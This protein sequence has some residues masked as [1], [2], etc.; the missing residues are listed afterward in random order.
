MLRKVE[1][2][3][4][5]TGAWAASSAGIST[6]ILRN[7]PITEIRVTVE[8]TPSATLAGANA[9]DGIFRVIQ[10]LSIVGGSQ[11]Y[12]TLPSK[13]E[14]VG[15]LLLHEMNMYDGAS[16]GHSLASITAPDHTYVPINFIFHAGV[17]PRDKY[18]KP[19]PFD[20]SGFIPATQENRLR[21]IWVTGANTVMDDTVTISS[22]TMR[23]TL[24]TLLGSEAEIEQ[25]MVEQ[26]VKL[27]AG[28]RAMVP[29][30]SAEM[31]SHTA[32]GS[33]YSIERNVPT[34]GFLR[35]IVIVQQDNTTTGGR[36][37]R[38]A[39]QV[40]GVAVKLGKDGTI[41]MRANMDQGLSNLPPA[42]ALMD[43]DADPLGALAVP[44]GVFVLDLARHVGSRAIGG[45]EY[46]LN[47]MGR[48]IGV[49]DIKLGFTITTYT[50]G[51]QSAILYE[52]L[53]PVL[54]G[55]RFA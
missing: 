37:L 15:G 1:E 29:Q 47:M 30:W 18:G 20:A 53:V 26:E 41:L 8:T 38:A 35:R 19:N 12:F 36:A 7:G 3:Q 6:D 4:V 17:R 40:T 11:T 25:E 42:S 48:E 9:P 14:P 27:P 33:D 44:Y 21:A 10:N 16:P 46:G 49:G 22:A 34:G 13:T 32:T 31:F 24:E 52:R 23:F 51:D 54:A 50:S 5:D 39:D 2:S 28:T 45:R 43:A 55:Q